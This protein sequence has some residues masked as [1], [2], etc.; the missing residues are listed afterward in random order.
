MS[1]Y[2]VTGNA[3]FVLI[4]SV[5]DLSEYDAFSRRFF[6]IARLLKVTVRWL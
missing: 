4:L 2:A 6:L 5:R 1:A 3:D